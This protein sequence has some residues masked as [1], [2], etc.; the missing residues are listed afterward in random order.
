MTFVEVLPV[1]N[2][3][4]FSILGLDFDYSN[5]GGQWTRQGKLQRAG[6]AQFPNSIKSK[7]SSIK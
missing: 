4:T 5:L 3:D 6:V 1:G 7:I 2:G